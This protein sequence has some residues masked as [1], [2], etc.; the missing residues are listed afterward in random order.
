MT[1]QAIFKRLTADFDTAVIISTAAVPVAGVEP[2]YETR[3]YE[4][5]MAAVD[6]VLTFSDGPPGY[7]E[8]L[9]RLS[10]LLSVCLYL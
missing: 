3:F 6:L 7:E 4:S 9:V 2:L 10:R 8:V 5:G 1:E